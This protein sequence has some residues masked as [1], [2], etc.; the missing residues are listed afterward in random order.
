MHKKVDLRQ[1]VYSVLGQNNNLKNSEIGKHFLQEDFKRRTIYDI[2][3]HEI[4]VPAEDPPRSGCKMSFN[5]KKFRHPKNAA[6]NR[7]SVNQRKRGKQFD[8]AQSTIR[9]DLKTVKCYK[10]QKAAK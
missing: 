8:V 5:G 10:R 1:H 3:K 6:A 2:I 9:S 4:G 7:I